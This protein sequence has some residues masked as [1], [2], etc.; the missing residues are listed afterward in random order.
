M[1][2]AVFMTT[3]KQPKTRAEI[4]NDAL[5]TRSEIIL[6]RNTVDHWNAHVRKPDERK[7]EFDADGMMQRIQDN[8]ETMIE[9]ELF[10]IHVIGPDEYEAAPSF[11][12]VVMR[13]HEANNFFAEQIVKGSVD[14]DCAPEFRV[15]AWPFTADE[16]AKELPKW[17]QRS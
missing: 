5:R 2:W 10:C 7:V 1:G 6:D 9:K 11:G 8:I 14:A 13:A 15:E 3:M 12:D 4:I 16:H 17:N